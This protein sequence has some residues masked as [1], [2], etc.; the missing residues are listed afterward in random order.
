MTNEIAPN[1]LV[2][3]RGTQL[4]DIRHSNSSAARAAS[5]CL[6]VVVFGEEGG[7]VA[8]PQPPAA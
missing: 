4:T 6:Q 8:G 2:R 5:G 7:G 1:D 3:I